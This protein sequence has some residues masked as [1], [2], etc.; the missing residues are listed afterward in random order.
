MCKDFEIKEY[1]NK[2]IHIFFFFWYI[3]K[4]SRF[5]SILFRSSFS[6]FD[7]K[8]CINNFFLFL[9]RKVI[10]FTGFFREFSFSTPTR[11]SSRINKT[12]RFYYECFAELLGNLETLIRNRT[13][14]WPKHRKYWLS[15]TDCLIY[16]NY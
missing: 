6:F 8:L 5:F 15:V 14:V 9:G 7:I 13:S 16:F 1:S 3:L 2:R 11:S 12:S 4:W 10:L